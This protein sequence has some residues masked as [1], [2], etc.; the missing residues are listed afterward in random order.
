MPLPD[1]TDCAQYLYDQLEPLQYAEADNDYALA[2]YCSAVA[3]P[4]DEIWDL[5]VTPDVPWSTV[6][7]TDVAP[8]KFLD[9]LGRFK[10]VRALVA[11]DA[12]KRERIHDAAGMKRGTLTSILARTRLH[13]TGTQHVT[14]QER[15][16][17]DAWKLR[18]TVYTAELV[19]TVQALRDDII[20]TVKPAGITLDLVVAA[21]ETWNEAGATTWNAAPGGMTWDTATSGI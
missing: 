16:D 11:D 10:G 6:V 5:V 19:G 15:A 13:L 21:S 4:F 7:D 14:I 17:S 12:T 18:I 1:L 9:W 3:T 2:K 8:A 20:N